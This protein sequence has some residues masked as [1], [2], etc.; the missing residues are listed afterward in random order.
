MIV[1]KSDP[2]LTKIVSESRDQSLPVRV[3]QSYGG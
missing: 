1:S 3:R 2:K